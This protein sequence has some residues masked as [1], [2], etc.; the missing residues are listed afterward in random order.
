MMIIALAAAAAS[1]QPQPLRTFA[2]WTVGCDNGH[3]CTAVVLLPEEDAWERDDYFQ[4]TIKRDAAPDAVPMIDWDNDLGDTPGTLLV[5]NRVIARGVRRGMPLTPA[6]ISALRRGHTASLRTD[7]AQTLNASLAGLT[8]SLLMID[9]RQGR[10]GTTSGLIRPG[11]RLMSGGGPALPVIV[12]PAPST[13]A[14]R[15][16]TVD[17]ARRIIGPD[18]A[19]CEDSSPPIGI[20]SYRLDATHSLALISHPCGNG[21]FNYFATAMIIDNAGRATPARFETDPGMGGEAGSEPGNVVVNARYDADQA[22]LNAYAKGRGVGDCGTL[23]DYVWDGTRFALSRLLQMG[24]CR[25]RINYIE[26]WRT[27]VR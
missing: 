9:D 10:V 2:D 4:L 5:D 12:R 7:S 22:I 3:A 8:A 17:E 23:S 18:N 1:A 26:V 19:T 14:P 11:R 25:G 15:T 16:V 21:A 24:E 27:V 13:A 20:E 6:M